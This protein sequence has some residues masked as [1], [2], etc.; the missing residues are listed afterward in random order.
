MRF[1]LLQFRANNVGFFNADK[2]RL[3]PLIAAGAIINRS[4]EIVVDFTGQKTFEHSFVAVGKP[5]N[6]HF[7]GNLCAVNE[8]IGIKRC[9]ATVNCHKA[10]VQVLVLA[11][12]I[13]NRVGNWIAFA[14][15]GPAASCS[16]QSN[17]IVVGLFI[18]IVMGARVNIFRVERRAFAVVS[19]SKNRTQ[20]PKQKERYGERQKCKNVEF[21]GYGSFLS[22]YGLY[23]PSLFQPDIDVQAH[24]FKC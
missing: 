2:T 4:L 23:M 17:N 15:V 22:Q 21:H 19:R 20:L 6:D 3:H 18:H 16:R 24:P 12:N 11:C 10:F 1:L 9:V 8:L 7:I 13:F 14:F 5:C